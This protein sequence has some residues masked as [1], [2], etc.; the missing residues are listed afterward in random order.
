MTE[1][2]L[3]KSNSIEQVRYG[4]AIG[5]LHT[6]AAIPRVVPI[7]HCGPGCADK[8]FMNLSY[9]NGFQGG[10]YGGG[11]VVPSTNATEREVVFGGADR[12]RELIGATLKVIDADLYVVVTGCIA[13][14]VG[15][16]VGAV[17]GEF[18]R[19]GVPIVYAET[20][21]FRGNNFTGHELVVKAIIDQYVGD[22]RGPRK[23]ATVNL[24]SLLPVHNT[25]WRG[26]LAELKR[27]LEG[28][29]LKVNVLFGHES[30][31]VREWK[32]IPKAQ[33]NLVL[34]PWLGV[35]VAQHLEKKYGQPWLH[36]PAIP[37]GAKET[38][39]FLR[40]VAQFAGLPAKRVEAF[41]RAEEKRYYLYL[42]DFSDF[43]A[44][45]WWGLPAKFAVIGDSAYNLALTRF[46]VNQLGLIPGRQIITE[47]PP[48]DVRDAIRAE[49]HAIAEDV[50][51]EV[52]F[53]EDSY[54]IHRKIRETDFGH[55]PP[56]IFGTTWERD[57]AKELKGALV[58]VGFPASYEVVINRAC[59]GYRGALSLLEKIY[60]T[61]VSASA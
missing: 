40:K 1:L 8:Q 54:V 5:A 16:D 9:Y 45:Y 18:Q 52:D 13:D 4:C 14:L 55:K 30:R 34:S 10:G 61:V 2:T 59:V 33:F 29:G 47:N 49:Y 17:V 53:E 38:G 31:G 12:L 39:A 56:I 35:S 22:Y 24:W 57:L 15:D 28:I 43:Y 19:R 21:G 26:D 48:D 42:E 51:A 50:S 46:L 37:I 44:E 41:I 36:I 6:A 60:T 58:E 3:E 7:T 32:D 27:I 23:E 11:A 25:F 20:G